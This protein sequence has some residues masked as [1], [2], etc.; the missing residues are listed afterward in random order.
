[1]SN[2]DLSF[3][4]KKSTP[5]CEIMGRNKSDKG[6]VNLQTCKHNY[7]TCYHHLFQNIRYQ[8][9]RIFELGIGTNNPYLPSSMGVD[10]RPGASLY[11]W[12]EY[13]PHSYIFGADI[14][15]NILFQTNRIKTFYCD[16]TDPN[17]IQQLWNEP[18][19]KDHEF[20]LI[21]EDGL[22]EL[23]AHILFLEQS[24]HKIN[25]DGYYVIEDILYYNIPAIKSKIKEWEVRYPNFVFSLLTIPNDINTLDNTLLI[26]HR[27]V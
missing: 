22:H 10:G 24:L 14:D 26:A 7:T 6:H 21:V 27:T 13:F 4:E 1:M 25:K 23:S 9:L 8:P 19:L 16:Q 3:D 2:L 5:L 17:S 20:D 15:R 12:A 18:S 11:G